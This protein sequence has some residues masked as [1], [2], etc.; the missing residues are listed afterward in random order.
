M[1]LGLFVAV[2]ASRQKR[3]GECAI[4]LLSRLLVGEWRFD[5]VVWRTGVQFRPLLARA[6]CGLEHFHNLN[7]VSGFA[8]RRRIGEGAGGPLLFS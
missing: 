6:E 8:S 7:F 2:G 4:F 5:F 3:A 1:K